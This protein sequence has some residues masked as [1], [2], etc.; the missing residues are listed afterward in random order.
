MLGCNAND[1]VQYYNMT[2]HSQCQYMMLEFFVE[3]GDP[4][5]QQL[6]HLPAHLHLLPKHTFHRLTVL[7]VVLCH[8]AV[9]PQSPLQTPHLRQS[10]KIGELITKYSKK[11][12][13]VCVYLVCRAGADDLRV[14]SA[15]G[16]LC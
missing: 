12:H 6:H 15:A 7:C 10:G 9:L 14:E 16:E 2:I 1:C 3:G 5:W 8:P 4:D 13:A 11:L